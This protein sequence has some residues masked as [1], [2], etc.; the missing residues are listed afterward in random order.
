MIAYDNLL[1]FKLLSSF[2]EEQG[3]VKST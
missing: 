3:N 2:L 1:K